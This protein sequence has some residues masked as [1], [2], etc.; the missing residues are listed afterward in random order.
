MPTE[1]VVSVGKKAGKGVGVYGRG[2]AARSTPRGGTREK[3]AAIFAKESG[4][5]LTNNDALGKA[6]ALIEKG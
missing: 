5:M 1:Q 6:C 3:E 2:A 4:E